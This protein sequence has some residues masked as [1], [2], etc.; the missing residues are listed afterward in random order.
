[1]NGGHLGFW[2]AFAETLGGLTERSSDKS[3]VLLPEDQAASL[4]LPEQLAV[5]TEPDLAREEGAVLLA[6]G[7]PALMLAA[8]RVLERG[9]VAIAAIE[10]ALSRPPDRSA[11]EQRARQQFPVDHGRIDATAAPVPAHRALL[12][13]GA[14]AEYTTGADEHYFERLE[15]WVDA[16][17]GLTVPESV[18]SA[19]TRAGWTSAAI[20]PPERSTTTRPSSSRCSAAARLRRRSGSGCSTPEPLRC[21]PSGIAGWPKSRTST[22]PSTPYGPTARMCCG[23]RRCA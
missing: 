9:D 18:T 2:L 8:E 19:V 6:P 14:L 1:M 16:H 12:R 3:L 10:P 21:V 5:T 11:L 7:H 4:G 13:V 23:C 20:P 17:S 22:T 15:T